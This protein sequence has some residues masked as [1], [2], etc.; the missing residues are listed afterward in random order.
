MTSLAEEL[1][2]R[3]VRYS[4]ENPALRGLPEK[5]ERLTVQQKEACDSILGEFGGNDLVVLDAPTGSGKTVIAETI[6]RMLGVGTTSYVCHSKN[7]QRQFVH[8]FGYAKLIEGRNNYPTGLKAELW[9]E[10]SCGE[11]TKNVQT[12]CNWCESVELCPYER[13]KAAALGAELCVLNTSYWLTECN[14]PG[15]FRGRKL[16]VFDEADTLE[17][18]VMGYLSVTV[19]RGLGKKLKL[20]EPEKVTKEESWL[21]WIKESLPKLQAFRKKLAGGV[22]GGEIKQLLALEGN[23]RRLQR[24]ERE[25]EEGTERWVYTGKDGLVEFKPARVDGVCGELIWRH[26]TKWLLMSA[27]TISA[28]ELVRSLGWSESYGVVT[29]PSTFPVGNRKIFVRSVGSPTFKNKEEEWPKI[30]GEVRRIVDNNAKVRILV[31]T[32]S[33][34]MS[35]RVVGMVGPRAIEYR[36]SSSRE[37]AIGRFR[38]REDGV[39][40][41]PSLSRGL[42]LSGD[43]CRVQIITKVPFPNL[44]DRQV[45][46]RM[47]GVNGQSWYVVQAIRELVQMTGRGVRDR[48]DWC[49]TYILDKAFRDNVWK[50]WRHL[51][52]KW[53]KEAV[54]W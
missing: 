34:E 38:E 23:I 19:P 37:G 8:D 17:K 11:C 13:A 6:R 10:L 24:I 25:L 33:Y 22:E 16:V 3:E 31:H 26:G 43:D 27:T 44:G 12:W 28:P 1:W 41:A 48:E 54:I 36:E 40:V 20:G 7:L 14:G 9:P 35:K 49:D 32:T 51:L 4:R 15:S 47:H 42:D 53:W 29:M 18:E 21:G 39:L 5:F 52:P 30:G 46:A 45:S 50:N 2:A